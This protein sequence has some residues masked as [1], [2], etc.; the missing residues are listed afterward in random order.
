MPC[1][2][3]PSAWACGSALTPRRRCRRPRNRPSLLQ[4]GVSWI[5]SGAGHAAVI[6]FLLYFL[7]LSGDHFTHR[8]LEISG[9]GV[10]VT[11]Q[12]LDE[13]NDQI[14]RFLLVTAFTSVVVGV[15]TW[16]ALAM[17][18]VRQAVVWGV[19]AGVFNS[20]PYFGPV[21]VSGGLFVI[22]FLQFGEPNG[23]AQSFRRVAG[24]YFTR[25]MDSHAAPARKGRAHARRRCFFGRIALDVA[26]G[27]VGHGARGPDDGCRKIDL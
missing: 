5:L 11:G 25:R 1:R 19:L 13:I 16:A 7:L 4:S 14:Q 15:I 26:V 12:V 20:I 24:H 18:N 6:V 3:R 8:F 21:I 23:G 9:H 27:S 17:L 2:K 10:R 22:G